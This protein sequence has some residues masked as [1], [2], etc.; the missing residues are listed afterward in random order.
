M[1]HFLIDYDRSNSAVLI[2]PFD[3]ISDAI[4]AYSQR[5]RE[6]F[7]TEHEIVLLGAESE[8]DLYETHARY[9]LDIAKAFERAV[10]RDR[11]RSEGFDRTL[12]QFDEQLGS[13]TDR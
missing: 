3:R 8:E 4:W 11:A 9:F 13:K 7:G 2:T 1:K 10:G 12:R 6:A 5:E